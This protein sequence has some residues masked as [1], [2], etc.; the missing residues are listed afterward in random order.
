M[1][2]E[3]PIAAKVLE[4]S[5]GSLYECTSL[6]RLSGGSANFTYRGTLTSPLPDTTSTIIIKHAEPYIAINSSWKLD[7]IRSVLPAPVITFNSYTDCLSTM[8]KLCSQRYDLSSQLPT[9][10]ST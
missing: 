5:E 7:V 8:S 1:V 10:T 4:D 2:S 3:D 9:Q 6:V